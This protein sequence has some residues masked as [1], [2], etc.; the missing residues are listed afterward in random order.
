MA[1]RCPP[2]RL[3]RRGR[4]PL[5]TA[6]DSARA[7]CAPLASFP[8]RTRGG[9]RATH[10]PNA[11]ERKMQCALS[12]YW[13]TPQWGY[14]DSE[15]PPRAAVV[16]RDAR[17]HGPQAKVRNGPVRAHLPRFA[18]FAARSP[19]A[20]SPVARGFAAFAVFARVKGRNGPDRHRP[21]ASARLRRRQPAKLHRSASQRLTLLKC[22][23]QRYPRARKRKTG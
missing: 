3:S 2:A 15:P 9:C 10:R 19:S 5:P 21:P 16:A 17:R 12:V 20:R 1:P 18:R 11:M 23:P 8:A 4:R 14:S 7:P 22:Y 13:L 6:T